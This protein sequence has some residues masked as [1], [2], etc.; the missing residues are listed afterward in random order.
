MKMQFLCALHRAELSSKS[1]L[2]IN[3]WQNGFD[4]GQLLFE[5]GMWHEAAPHLGC[6]FET[7]EIILST[8]A[9]DS[10]NAC[11]LFTYSA[12]LLADTFTKIHLIRHA[13][14][15]CTL[16]ITRLERELNHNTNTQQAIKN[17]LSQVYE[18]IHQIDTQIADSAATEQNAISLQQLT[19]TA[20]H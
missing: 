6:A 9:V 13:H 16:T 8:R 20:N 3:C 2:A 4:A 17:N 1:N 12:L 7:A 5:Q 11:E 15:I 19:F 10:L 18:R 14:A